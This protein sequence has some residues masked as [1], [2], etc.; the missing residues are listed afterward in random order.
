MKSRNR[1]VTIILLVLT[2]AAG[3]ASRH[4]AAMLPP[5][6]Q[7]NAGDI[8]WDTAV[9]FVLTVFSPKAFP[10]RVMLLS[11]AVGFAVEFLKLCDIPALQEIRASAIGGS[12]L[13]HAFSWTNLVCYAIGAL[14]A[15]VV[16]L[17]LGAHP[18]KSDGGAKR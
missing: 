12:V 9:Y 11:I 3:L 7:K 4:F 16:D 5:I 15:M 18:G 14:L 2:I 17:L 13:G 6:L 1:A 10:G 8:L